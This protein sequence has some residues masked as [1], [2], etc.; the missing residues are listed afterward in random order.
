MTILL[1][2]LSLSLF[3]N[4]WTNSFYTD[5]SPYY[6]KLFSNGFIQRIRISNSDCYSFAG[7]EIVVQGHNRTY[8]LERID[9]SNMHGWPTFYGLNQSNHCWFQA[10]VGGI[11]LN[12]PDKNNYLIKLKS[13]NNEEFYFTGLHN[14]LFIQDRIKRASDNYKPWINL[15]PHGATLVDDGGVFFKIWEPVA[16][17]VDLFFYGSASPIRMHGNFPRGNNQ[18]SHSVFIKEAKVNHQYY[19]RFIKNGSYEKAE[20]ANNY[21]SD[22][23]I[24]PMTRHLT[25]DHKGGRFNGYI[26]PRSV[27]T[28]PQYGVWKNDGR[29][30]QRSSKNWDNWIIYQLWPA[31]F[32][33]TSNGNS[34]HTG[35]FDSVA[36][37]LDYLTH[38]GVNAVEFLPVQESRF[39]VSWGYALD[40]LTA[41]EST[42][43]GPEKLKRLVDQI[44][45]RGLRVILDIV[46]NHVN[47]SLIRDPL[48][49][50]VSSSKFY[51][52]GTPWGPKPN[53]NNIMVRKWILDSLLSQMRE[54]HID[55]FRFDMTKYVYQNS[56][57]GYR[58]LQELTHILKQN[59]P[60]FYNSAEELPDNVWITKPVNQNGA[61]FDS[62]WNDKFKNFF[63][64]DLNYYR[65]YNRKANLLHLYEAMLGYSNHGKM[66]YLFFEPKTTVNYLGSHDF[67]GNKDT[68][69]RIVSNYRSTEI[70]AHNTFYRVRPLED[71]DN[72]HEKFRMIHNDFTHSLGKLSYGI[73]FSKPGSTLFFQGE[74]IA[75]DINIEN[76]W[77]YLGATRGNT[78]PSKNI[79]IHRYVNSHK[80]PWEYYSPLTRNTLNF[81]KPE[82]KMLF[83]GYHNFFKDMIK[84]KSINPELN[85]YNAYNIDID[86][87]NS[88]MTYQINSGHL[89]YF[90][91]AN[92]GNAQRNYWMK[93]PNGG[94]NNWWRE[95]IDS[96]SR[97]YG[98]L[99]NQYNNIFTNWG[100]RPN[101]I[102]IA[103]TSF[104]IFVAERSPSVGQQL[105]LMNDLDG[106]RALEHLKL[107]DQGN[108]TLIADVGIKSDTNFNFKLATNDW[109]IA[110]GASTQKQDV[111]YRMKGGTQGVLSY[112]ISGPNA[113]NYLPAGNYRFIFNIYTFEYQ[114]IKQ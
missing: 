110:I 12:K 32:V 67:I 41:I 98:G 93:F 7:G 5:D 92:F 4:S 78:T 81:L 84:F 15:G 28:A 29:V 96:S 17:A 16:D 83:N 102:R 70:D 73:L 47:N 48:S 63:E 114:F 34:V 91:I 77:S 50:T 59:N 6:L 23:K 109:N 49:R 58:M 95:F 46:I 100:G 108:G 62:Q 3:A 33:P 19:Y 61:G 72:P 85:M 42:L 74:E 80:M 10:R 31:T 53:F 94:T 30:F 37:G 54:Y 8:P 13:S 65:A 64:H 43:G 97:R 35:N 27:V 75:S 66:Q 21:F 82:E 69:L 111:Y 57:A 52:G 11:D 56:P 25:Y 60:W 101:L 76:E 20:T 104:R 107:V 106:W 24:D 71:P 88:I 68:I 113:T 40:S 45:G 39:Y 22:I 18:R 1:T 26:N 103:P 87:Q 14:S 112:D 55:G 86:Y 105:Y 99:T 79:D 9:S 90:V 44:H 51:S 36:G 89:R 38:L 2:F